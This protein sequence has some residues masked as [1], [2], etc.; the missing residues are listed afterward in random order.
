MKTVKQWQW[1]KTSTEDYKRIL[2][3]DHLNIMHQ[4]RATIKGID[5]VFCPGAG[6]SDHVHLFTSDDQSVLYVLAVNGR[7][8]YVGLERY[9]LDHGDI[10]HDDLEDS[11]FFQS[12]YCFADLLNMDYDKI[13]KAIDKF[14]DYSPMY[15]AKLLEVYLP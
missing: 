11:V 3:F 12:D 6:S 13:D 8:T 7:Y 4:I 9:H 5:Y 2:G 14:F 1:E 10:A 15:Q